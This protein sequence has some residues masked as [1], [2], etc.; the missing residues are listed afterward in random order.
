MKC[1][2]PASIGSMQLKNRFLFPSM[3]NFYCDDEGFVTPRLEAYVRARVQGGAAAVIMPG[4]P[5]GK[6]G[7]ARPALSDS[8]YASGWRRLLDICREKGCRLIVQIHPA[9]AQAGRDPSVLL[10]DNMPR[11]KIRQIVSSYAACARAA[12]EIGL[13]G[14]E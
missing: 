4:S 5:H 1:L 2:T 3:C 11:E 7:P 8:R 12:R 10:P 14:A 13:D 9:K 6:P